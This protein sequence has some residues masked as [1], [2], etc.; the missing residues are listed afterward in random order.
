MI[1]IKINGL[2]NT[3]NKH[4][5]YPALWMEDGNIFYIISSKENCMEQID[6]RDSN[7]KWNIIMKMIHQHH[8][9]IYLVL[10]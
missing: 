2:P 10:I 3:N 6:L 5:T 1:L 9:K 4:G 7:N 8:L